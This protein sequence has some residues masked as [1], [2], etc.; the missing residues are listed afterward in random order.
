[1]KHPAR[2]TANP[3]PA[4]FPGRRSLIRAR[5]AGSTT[6]AQGDAYTGETEAS[7]GSRLR[8]MIF[9][10][11]CFRQGSEAQAARPPAAPARAAPARPVPAS[12][13]PDKAAPTAGGAGGAGGRGV[14]DGSIQR[15]ESGS[16]HVEHEG[17]DQPSP[18]TR[19]AEP[20]SGARVPASRAASRTFASAG[21]VCRRA[22]ARMRR[23]GIPGHRARPPAWEARHALSLRP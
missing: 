11:H 15:R 4:R 16:F 10:R 23:P 21:M 2:A 13:V 1:M 18:W 3:A 20:R 8:P 19:R 7:G 22:G 14:S 9:V 12:A 5:S 17:P 6:S